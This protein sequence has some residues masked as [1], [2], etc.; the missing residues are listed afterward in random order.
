MSDEKEANCSSQT[1]VPL[2]STTTKIVSIDISSSTTSKKNPGMY[3]IDK[4]KEKQPPVVYSDKEARKSD[5][6]NNDYA[7]VNENNDSQDDSQYA[8]E[9]VL[10][11]NLIAEHL[12]ELELNNQNHRKDKANKENVELKNADDFLDSFLIPSHRNSKNNDPDDLGLI[13]EKFNRK[14][15][16]SSSLKKTTTKEKIV[17]HGKKQKYCYSR[18]CIL[19]YLYL[20]LCLIVQKKSKS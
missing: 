7:D 16:T 8:A 12:R 11:Q 19:V 17:F 9:L 6:N 1:W 5:L 13:N 14:L 2:P 18:C 20:V 4:D 10:R 15:T 3:F